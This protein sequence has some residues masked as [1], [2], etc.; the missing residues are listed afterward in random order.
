MILIMVE[1]F[2]LMVFNYMK[3]VLIDLI[4]VFFICNLEVL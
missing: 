4:I 3:V 2:E 1:I